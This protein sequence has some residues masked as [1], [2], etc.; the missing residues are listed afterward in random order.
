MVDGSIPPILQW[1]LAV[2]AELVR[3]FRQVPAFPTVCH[4]VSLLDKVG[5]LS[6]DS[7]LGLR[8]NNRLL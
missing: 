3:V 8:T 5:Q 1:L 6:F 2:V 7:R 4:A